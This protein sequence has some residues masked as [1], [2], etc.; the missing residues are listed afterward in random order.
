MGAK[1]DDHRT[2]SARTN[3]IQINEMNLFHFLRSSWSNNALHTG[4]R[5][6]DDPEHRWPKLHILL[7]QRDT[8]LHITDSFRHSI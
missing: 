6:D 1:L 4:S 7:H 2:G 3:D 5:K 8:E